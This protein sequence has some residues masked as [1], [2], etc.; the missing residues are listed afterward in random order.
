[1]RSTGST[2]IISTGKTCKA[3]VVSILV[4][5]ER[6]PLSY[7]YED[8]KDLADKVGLLV[9]EG[10]VTDITYNSVDR[11]MMSEALVEYLERS[12]AE[13]PTSPRLE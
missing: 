12:A 1:M 7:Y 6:K 11:Y 13:N 3:L 10:G 8:H 2:R 4:P 9:N 5:Q